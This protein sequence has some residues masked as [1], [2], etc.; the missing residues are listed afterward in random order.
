MFTKNSITV[1][2]RRYLAKNEK[3][4]VTETIEEMFRRV[5]RNLS[6]ADL[7]YNKEEENRKTTE[8]EFYQVMYYLDFLPNSP[9]LMNAGRR[10]Q[11][12]SACFVLPVEDS[13][14]DIF[15]KVKMTAMIHKSGGG[16]GFSFSR[17]RPKGD[18]VG[19]TGGISSGPTSFILAF[20]AATDVVKQGGTRRGA[21][22]GILNI[23][24]PDILD[25]ITLKRDERKL[26]NFN[27]SVGVDEEFIRKVSNNEEY[28]LINPRNGETTGRLNAR[29]VFN[30]ITQCA[31]ET[32][33][34][35]M[36]FLDRMNK[37]HPNRHLG[38]IESC[39]PCGE[40]PL[41]PYESCNL[42][43][44]N[45]KNMVD[46]EQINWDRLNRICETAVHML[47]NV[48]DMNRYPIPEIEEMTKRTR[49]I[50]VGV[51]GL[52][53][54]LVK[55]RIRYDSDEGINTVKGLM[56]FIKDSVHIAS[57]KLTE[58]RGCY[59]EWER[60][61]YQ[62]LMRNTAPVTIAPTGT[63]SIIAGVS[64][65]VEPLY[66]LAYTRTVM[67]NDILVEANEELETTLLQTLKEEELKE[68]LRRIAETGSIQN[69]DGIPQ[70]IKDI[71][72]VSHDISPEWHIKM[73][74]AVQGYTDN[75]VSKT[76]N[77]PHSATVED[78]RNAYLLA[79]ESGCKGIT[80]F[81][82]G[83]KSKQVLS[84]TETRVGSPDV[85]RAPVLYGG[86]HR[87]QTGHGT[88][89]AT[90]NSDEKGNI[91]EA[92]LNLGKSESCVKAFTEAIGRLVSTS[93]SSGVPVETIA[94]QLEGISCS[95]TVWNNGSQ[96]L[97]VPDALGKELLKILNNTAVPLLNGELCP[98]CG[99]TLIH[100][101][102]C[103][104]CT[105]CGFSDCK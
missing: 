82:D 105:T 40:Q 53:D 15:D 45:L 42:G 8:E 65:G 52:A 21:N 49:R 25:F 54:M 91:V 68:M 83:S 84:T 77:L 51:M 71:F 37:D 46:G 58:T 80:I 30:L 33:D 97:S 64:S 89:Y 101:E 63:I 85:K 99:N 88:L 1:L 56:G 39:N 69:V 81:R 18:V 24:H 32:G 102:G 86:T 16:T 28:D 14:E 7:K 59:P 23:N 38:E 66:A 75:A 62:Y 57:A 67:D 26:Q 95:H 36:V 35:G 92:F 29:E 44:I 93:L 87:I 12:L 19:S 11:Q 4:E 90:I 27:I 3:G 73:Q 98:E 9:T 31:W 10:L 43:S 13:L 41:L 70:E 47:D 17:L 78:V 48:I 104:T 100:V 6:I 96:I 55:M 103:V 79:H 22:M 72:R 5:A 20:D 2:N 94:R 61:T 34:P 74:A 50:G 60:S 76:I